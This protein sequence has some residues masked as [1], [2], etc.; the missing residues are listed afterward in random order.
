MFKKW[1]KH[2]CW[3]LNEKESLFVVHFE[4]EKGYKKV[5][6]IISSSTKVKQM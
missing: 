2:L 6:T 1:L 5:E 4:Y 3:F